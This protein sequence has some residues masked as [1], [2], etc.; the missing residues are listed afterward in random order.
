MPT[1]SRK[2]RTRGRRK[3]ATSAATDLGRLNF[4]FD[5]P[6]RPATPPMPVR[7]VR[8]RTVS[9]FTMLFALA[10][11]GAF[12]AG[13]PP[14]AAAG[15]GAAEETELPMF[16][17]L[18]T[19]TYPVRNLQK[20]KAWYASVLG[21]QPHFDQT[22]YVGFDVG[23]YELSLVPAKDAEGRQQAS[24][25]AYWEVKDARAAYQRLMKLGATEMEPVRDVGNGILV[26]TVHDP[27][28]NV[29]G[30]IQNPN[31]KEPGN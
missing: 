15:P 26:G 19:A 20:A 28:G 12:M 14:V 7:G 25:V 24:G 1:L 2:L 23:G 16:I 11:L 31:F 21:V 17:G 5:A 6:L 8:L 3:G 29:L 30:I 13:R 4:N 22:F 9:T 10:C 18:R 27:F